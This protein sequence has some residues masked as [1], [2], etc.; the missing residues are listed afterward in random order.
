MA[1]AKF[2]NLTSVIQKNL[3]TMVRSNQNIHD[4]PPMTSYKGDIHSVRRPVNTAVPYYGYRG[5]GSKDF[6]AS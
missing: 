1:N 3:S 2:N 4:M 5:V 6:S